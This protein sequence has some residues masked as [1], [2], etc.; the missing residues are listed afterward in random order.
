MFCKQRQEEAEQKIS[1]TCENFNLG[2]T[3]GGLNK[4]PEL[5]I[6]ISSAAS[7]EKTN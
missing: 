3:R 7:M 4:L 2:F 1:K 5:L 6:V